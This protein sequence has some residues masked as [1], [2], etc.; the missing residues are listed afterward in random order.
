MGVPAVEGLARTTGDERFALDP[1]PPAPLVLTALLRRKTRT[2]FTLLALFA[3]TVAAM[4][5]AGNAAAQDAPDSIQRVEIT[6]S[7]IKR[8]TAE[9]AS[10]VQV[11]SREELMSDARPVTDSIDG[12]N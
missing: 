8:A 7:S 2:T 3:G 10:P 12:G 6:G 4:G 11:V 5:M 9:T 1:L